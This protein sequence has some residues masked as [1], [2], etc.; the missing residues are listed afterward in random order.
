MESMAPKRVLII[1]TLVACANAAGAQERTVI[2][3]SRLLDV[4]R[5]VLVSDARV[6]VQGDRIVAIGG[7]D[8]AGARHLRLG[9]VTLLPGLIDVHTHLTFDLEGDWVNRPVKESAP[10]WA[11]RGAR[12]ARRTLHAGFTTVRDVGAGAGFVDLALMRAIDHGFVE[13][14]R[15]IPSGH[16]L[17]IT[18]G[19]CDLTGFAPR[20]AE[21]DWR[22]GVADG[23]A[24]VLKAVRYQAKH[25]ARMIK[26]CATAGVLSFEGPVG[27]QQYSE[28]ELRAL[29]QE[30]RRHGLRVAAHAH[31]TEGI[32]AAARAGVTS[33]EH[34][35]FL[36]PAAAAVLKELGTYYVPNLYLLEVLDT[37]DLPPP[38]REKENLVSPAIAASFQRAVKAGLK[39]AF[40]TDAGV[41]PHG[42]NAKEFHARVR[43]GMSR[44]EAIRGATLYAAEVLG[45]D[46]RG[47]I[48]PGK[49]ADLIAVTGNPLENERV[50]ERV[51]FVMKGGTVVRAP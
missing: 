13:G 49:L 15:M 17:G 9:D 26:V 35:S 38:L 27:A 18:G 3:A 11:L 10:D 44:L 25:G 37:V 50:L 30:A 14:P 48:A 29:V 32:I 40:G 42:D 41:Y 12:N 8:T 7:R 28:E 33:I 45:V 34:G 20:V 43:Q 19:H 46:D 6:L 2:H 23:V 22:T 24:E 31:G 4:S 16:S 47:V 5:G 36:T 39:I 21:Q 1:C 51:V